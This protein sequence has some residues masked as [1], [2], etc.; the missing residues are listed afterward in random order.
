MPWEK[1]F[2]IVKCFIT[3]DVCLSIMMK[4]HSKC[5]KGERRKKASLILKNKT[6]INQ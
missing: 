1:K 2:T 6:A 4:A 3:K 5:Y